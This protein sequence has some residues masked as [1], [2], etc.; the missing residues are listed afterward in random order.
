M[1]KIFSTTLFASL[2]SFCA[3]TAAAADDFDGDLISKPHRIFEIGVD[4]S[5]GFA[6]S[7][8]NFKDVFKKDLVIDLKK[9][10]ND[11]PKDGFSLGLYNEENVFVNLNLSSRFRFGLFTGVEASAHFNIAKDLF[12]ILGDGISANDS[13]SVDVTGYADIFYNVGASFQTLVKGYAIRVTPT[14]VVPV[15]YV[16]KT[17]ATASVTTNESGLITAHAEADVD[18]YTAVNMHDFM[19]DEKSI[20]NLDLAVGDILSN[21]GFDLS[22]EVERNW[23]HGFNAGLY[24]R[25]PIIGG[26]LNNRMSTR[27]Y[28]DE[29]RTEGLINDILDDTLTDSKPEVHH[30]YKDEDGEEHD[31]KYSDDTYK[32]YRPLKLGLN[33]TYMPFGSWLKIQPSLGFAVRNPYSGDAIFYPEYALDLRLS[34]VKSIFNFNVGTAYQNQV[35]QQRFGFALNLRAIEIITQASLC[36]TNLLASFRRDGYGAFIG[37]RMGF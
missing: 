7:S 32:V 26:K 28:V 18:I 35:F 34:L 31:Y 19:E 5:A 16:P 20:D 10:S 3:I 37:F 15:V 33:A 2:F 29:W 12:D 14:Y 1:K 13:K 22:L 21:G 25:I 24:T 11:M 4:A 36:G 6:N 17:K 23:L 27:V 8:L 9:I 30:G